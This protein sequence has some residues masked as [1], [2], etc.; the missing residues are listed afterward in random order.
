MRL[1]QADEVSEVPEAPEP[2]EA[3]EL[4][5]E[6]L[7]PP[8]PP[9]PPVPPA[10]PAPPAPVAGSNR[11]IIQKTVTRD[12]DQAA[13]DGRRHADVARRHAEMARH[14]ADEALARAPR[15]EETVS[16]DGKRRMIR[17][18]R[19]DGV[20]AGGQM[21]E[22]TMVLDESCPADSR[23][24]EARS[25]GNGSKAV[26]VICTGEPTNTHETAIRALRTAR[27]SIASERNLDAQ[28]RADILA[29]LDAEIAEEAR[30]S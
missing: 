17:I 13:R 20:G 30:G 18:E 4:P 25:E 15:V 27:A 3:P 12:A 5:D 24:R 9:M 28:V 8:A 6:G 1:A 21:A 23:R 11:V 14:Q 29:D 22:Q 26:V 2:P 16:A 7:V 10:P 19:R